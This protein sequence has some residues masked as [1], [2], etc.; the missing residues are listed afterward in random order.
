MMRPM[1]I[2]LATVLAL[3]AFAQSDAPRAGA[4]AFSGFKTYWAERR[5]GC[6]PMISFTVRN[7]SPESVGPIDI[8]MEV[9]DKDKGAV[10]A[11]GAAT[12]A[13]AG[14]PPGQSADIAIGGDHDITPRDCRGDMHQSPFSAIH[15]TVRLTAKIGQDQAGVEILRDEPMTQ[16]R[17][18][19]QD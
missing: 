7:D 15:F 4:A 18:P 9:V 2:A 11:G 6:R 19:A 14:L 16:Q 3:P 1:L 13:S 5:D 10:F 8:R 17:V 12:V